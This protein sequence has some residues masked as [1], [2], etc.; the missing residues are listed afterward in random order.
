MEL[1]RSFSYCVMY[2][3]LVAAWEFAMSF[4]TRPDDVL[5][6]LKAVQRRVSF[7]FWVFYKCED[8]EEYVKVL[9]KSFKHW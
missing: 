9:Y 3:S 8:C 6:T 2:T 1:S 5:V 4:F 7:V